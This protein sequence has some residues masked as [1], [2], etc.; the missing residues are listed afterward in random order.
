[1]NKEIIFGFKI[2]KM[3]IKEIVM[4]RKLKVFFCFVKYKMLI[5]VNRFFVNI[6]NDII[7]IVVIKV[8]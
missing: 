5:I 4:R 2:F 7:N 1:M 3:F 8:I 6:M